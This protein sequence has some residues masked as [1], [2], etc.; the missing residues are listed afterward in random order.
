MKKLLSVEA[1]A[2][3]GKTFRLAN[4]YIALLNLDNPVNIIAITFTNKAANEMK[5]RI[6]KFLN[7]LKKSDD[8]LDEKKRKEKKNIIEMICNELGINE[9]DLLSKT[10]ILIKKF[11][12]ND[13]NI[14]TIDSFINK[15]LRKFS[16]FAGFRSN[17]DVGDIDREIIFKEFLKDLKTDEFKLLIDIAKKEEKF[18]SLLNLFE[19]LYEKDKELQGVKSENVNK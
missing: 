5:E 1:S 13:V 16:F 10:D 15:I 8:K 9:N 14:Q 12:T 11:L 2:G 4:R 17:F 18:S 19:D 7:L 6:V 3:S